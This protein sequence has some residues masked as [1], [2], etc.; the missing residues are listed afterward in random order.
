M[1]MNDLRNHDP[2]K[3]AN[4]LRVHVLQM[5]HSANSSHVGSCL[6]I[7]DILAVLYCRVLRFDSSLPDW[8]ERDRFILS[9]GHAAA[10]VYAVLAEADFFPL[11]WL[12][13]YSSNKSLLFG[14]ITSTNLPGVEISTGSLGHG[15]PVGCGM[16]LAGKRD[17]LPSRVFVLLSD[18]EL[19]EGS[20]W[21]AI[22]FAHQH[23]L[24]NLT[25][26]LDYN[27]IQ[28]FG[29]TKDV[30]DLEPLVAKWE[31]FGWQV[32]EIDGHDSDEILEAL[33]HHPMTEGKPSVIV[34][35]T[36]KGKGVSF[37]ENQLDWHYK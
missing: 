34:A 31:A 14:H 17:G 5:L 37:M 20:N 19:D 29:N 13:D 4:K 10:A 35:H 32:Q 18:G 23:K 12:N 36:V 15:L 2:A 27:R 11:E 3:L 7:A 8:P 26:L 28:G 16:A 24:D 33:E 1:T 21:E 25:V 6:S 22:L 9:K 30:I